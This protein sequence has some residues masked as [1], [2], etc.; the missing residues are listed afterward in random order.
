[1]NEG[2]IFKFVAVANSNYRR[3]WINVR[4]AKIMKGKSVPTPIDDKESETGTYN[5]DGHL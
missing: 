2:E 1:M 4:G 3:R 5:Y